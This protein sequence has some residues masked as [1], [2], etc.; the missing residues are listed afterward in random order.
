[1][2]C[3][4]HKVTGEFNHC[5]NRDI[6]TQI[7][8]I[9]TLK[10]SIAE[11]QPVFRSKW[12]TIRKRWVG[13]FLLMGLIWRL[14]ALPLTTFTASFSDSATCLTNGLQA[15]Q[16]VLNFIVFIGTSRWVRSKWLSF[17]PWSGSK[18]TE[19][20]IKTASSFFFFFDSGTFVFEKARGFEFGRSESLW[21]WRTQEMPCSGYHFCV[22]QMA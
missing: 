20:V 13:F 8:K 2:N 18:I 14:P 5:V 10:T 22:G 19:L 4:L 21:P 3:S 16:L 11:K 15:V 9:Q 7:V 12:E 1:M 17:D 6:Q